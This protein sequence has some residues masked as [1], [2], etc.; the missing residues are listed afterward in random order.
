MQVA[1]N[2]PVILVTDSNYLKYIP[3]TQEVTLY[4]VNGLQGQNDIQLEK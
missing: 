2:T 1:A 3:A 4:Q